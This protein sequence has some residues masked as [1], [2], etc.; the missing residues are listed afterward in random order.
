MKNWENK[1]IDATTPTLSWDIRRQTVMRMVAQKVLAQNKVD[2]FVNPPLLT[3]PGKIGA[4]G[5]NG[6]G[7]GGANAGHGF[8]A[9]LGVPEVFV[10]AG[11]SDTIYDPVVKL[12]DDGTEYRSSPG[13]TP[14]KL[15]SPLPFTIDFWAAPGDETVILK[16]ASAYEAATHHR[17]APPGFG[18]VTDTRLS[19]R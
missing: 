10:P 13:T 5:G 16:V 11:F 19:S 6:G 14:T 12:S 17:K 4:A 7:G 1:A 9:S 2:V 18:P 15:A 8:G 3:L